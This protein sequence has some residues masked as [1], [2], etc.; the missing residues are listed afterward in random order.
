VPTALRAILAGLLIL[1]TRTVFAWG[2]EVFNKIVTAARPSSEPAA[3][4]TLVWSDEFSEHDG[5]APNP[6]NWTFDTGGNGWGNHELQ[7]YTARSPDNVVIQ[8][9]KL[10]IRAL[11]ETYAGP[12]AVTRPFTSARLLSQG[13]FALTYGRFEARIKIPYGMGLW[14]AFWMLGS[15]IKEVGWPDCGEIDILENIGKEPSTVHGTIHGPGYSQSAGI[16][17]SYTLPGNRR[18][19]DGFHVF[20][21]EWEPGA[22]RFYVDDALY[23]TTTPADLPPGKTWVFD[24]PFFLILNVAVGGDWP[25]NPDSSTVFP[26][27]M[28]VDYVRV[29]QRR[30]Q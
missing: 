14:P 18:F 11:R 19:A 10:R 6:R 7:Y 17:A 13:R 5:S 1:A 24:H 3:A 28:D 15:N 27:I 4:W 2:P 9:G 29:Y 26:Q 20:A 8:D 12:D 22:V 21:A 25:G 23:K 16:G 30:A